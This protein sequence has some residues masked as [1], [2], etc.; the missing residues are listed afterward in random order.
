[1]HSSES[2]FSPLPPVP[3]GPTHPGPANGIQTWKTQGTLQLLAHLMDR[4]GTFERANCLGETQKEEP[5]ILLAE[6]LI[7]QI[8]QCREDEIIE[9]T[10]CADFSDG[11]FV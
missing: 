11:P 10:T 9:G 2:S 8:G 4:T 7:L 3:A 5:G 1:M 6:V